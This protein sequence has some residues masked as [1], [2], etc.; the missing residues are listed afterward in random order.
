VGGCISGG[1]DARRKRK[2]CDVRHS[3]RH[4]EPTPASLPQSRPDRALKSI[5]RGGHFRR[6][7]EEILV[8]MSNP[9]IK[10]EAGLGRTADLQ[11]QG[12]VKGG[13]V[14]LGSFFKGNKP[15][16]RNP[17]K[18]EAPPKKEGDASEIETRRKSKDG[19]GA[20]RSV[21]D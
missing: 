18:K 15:L 19:S 12:C 17:K 10:K 4:V 21:R 5:N 13:D 6:G 2:T 8:Q 3:R 20:W 1:G 16:F 14:R 7:K 11:R 9:K